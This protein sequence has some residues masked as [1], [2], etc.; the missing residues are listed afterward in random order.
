MRFRQFASTTAAPERKRRT[1]S[2][3]GVSAG[4]VSRTSITAAIFSAGLVSSTMKLLLPRTWPQRLKTPIAGG[5]C[6]SAAPN[7]L[8]IRSA[9]LLRKSILDHGQQASALAG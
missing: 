4:L 5:R 9:S 3:H 6:G 1:G 8:A 7:A 2:L